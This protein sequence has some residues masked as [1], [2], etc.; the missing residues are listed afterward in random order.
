MSVKV[1]ILMF[2]ISISI[3]PANAE[4]AMDIDRKKPR[5][6]PEQIKLVDR[7]R[8]LLSAMDEL[9]K[10]DDQLRLNID[11]LQKKRDEVNDAMLNL[12]HELNSIRLQLV[13]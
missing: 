6:D 7:E 8:S 4:T 2:L 12:R 9:K 3:M 10:A 11:V 5:I 13:Q 1:L